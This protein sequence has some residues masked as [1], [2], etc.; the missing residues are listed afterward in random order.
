M[1]EQRAACRII[2]V[3]GSLRPKSHTRHAVEIALAGAAAAGA[4]VEFVDLREFQLP[5]CP[6]SASAL[7]AYP[8]VARWRQM[9]QNSHAA[10]LGSPEYH[11]SFSGVLK[12]AL[13]LS[14]LDDWRGKLIALIGVSGGAMGPVGALSGLRD[15]GRGL[16]AWVMP[17][18]VAIAAAHEAFD[19][20]GHPRDDVRDRLVKLG[21]QAAHYVTSTHS[22]HI[23]FASSRLAGRRADD[24]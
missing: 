23:A 14:E 11:G 4:S 8:E 22:D 17:Q 7:A 24:V 20:R 1:N 18:Q 9:I 10:I 13:D 21:Q 5:L 2:G 19:D 16:H 3:S 6:G 12:N 15:V